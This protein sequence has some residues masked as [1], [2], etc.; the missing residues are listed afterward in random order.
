MVANAATLKLVIMVFACCAYNCKNRQVAEI[1]NKGVT[2][3]R[4]PKDKKIR[5][6]WVQA[7]HRIDPLTKKPWQPTK[8]SYI[9]S[10][11]FRSEDFDRTGQT[12]RLKQNVV[13]SVFQ[14]PS[15]LQARPVK[16][17][18]SVTSRRALASNTDIAISTEEDSSRN[19]VSTITLIWK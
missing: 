15:H 19:T 6:L 11:H 13:P 3:H 12:V 17:R 10:Q 18:N 2:F 5:K 7:L 4:I 9:C 1:K 16:I 8:Y 14:F